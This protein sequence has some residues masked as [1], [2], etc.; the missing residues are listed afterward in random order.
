MYVEES[1]SN[2]DVK[3]TIEL[4]LNLETENTS[5]FGFDW[6]EEIE[7]EI[8][9]LIIPKTG[10]ILGLVSLDR[11]FEELR[12]EIRLLELSKSNIGASKKYEK[13]AGILIAHCCKQSFQNGFFGFVS[14][15]PKTKLI[16]HYKK[17]YGFQQFGKHLVVDLDKSELLMKKYLLNEKN[18]K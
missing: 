16:N 10:E 7:Y 15:I 11:V 9:K 6:S 4:V 12:I 18:K 1:K 17:E 5:K 2:K 14:L 8:Y 3:V 13:V